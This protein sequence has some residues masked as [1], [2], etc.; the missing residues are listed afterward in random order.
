[1]TST[2]NAKQN[3]TAK[4]CIATNAEK[5]TN[6]AMQMGNAAKEWNVNMV[7]ALKEL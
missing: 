3:S 4:E 2:N 1:M 7:T 6:I 5:T